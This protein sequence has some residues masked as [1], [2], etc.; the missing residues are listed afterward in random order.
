MGK[1]KVIMDVEKEINKQLVESLNKFKKSILYMAGDAP[2]A[3]L[4]LPKTIENIL[5]ANG[6]DRVY[7]IFDLD[8]TKVKGLGS[9][10]RRHL[11]ASLNEFLSV[12]S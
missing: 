5:L 4:C 3:V 6:L 8:L 11:T 7:C 9:M 1:K 10:R 12:C 2:I